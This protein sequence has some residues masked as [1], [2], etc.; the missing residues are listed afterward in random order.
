M[1]ICY[2]MSSDETNIAVFVV[3]VVR[4]DS[5]FVAR[6]PLGRQ[7]LLWNLV[8]LAR[9]CASNVLRE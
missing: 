7:M 2:P 6:L 1:E 9:R 3:D 8:G 5:L 4:L